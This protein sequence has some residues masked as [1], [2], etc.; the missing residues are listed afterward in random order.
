MKREQDISGTS[1]AA[2]KAM[3]PHSEKPVKQDRDDYSKLHNFNFFT[4][5]GNLTAASGSRFS[6][7]PPF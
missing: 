6:P 1:A 3:D 7:P 5:A 2:Y 4:Q